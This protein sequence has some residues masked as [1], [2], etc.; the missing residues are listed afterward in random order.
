MRAST[1]AVVLLVVT[2]LV[3]IA[4]GVLLSDVVY[5]AVSA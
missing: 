3:S 1:D 5:L 4:L 2:A